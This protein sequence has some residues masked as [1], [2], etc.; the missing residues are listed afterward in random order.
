MC[1]LP[2]LTLEKAQIADPLTG[3]ITIIIAQALA[4]LVALLGNNFFQV[5]GK[6][7]F[8]GLL[9]KKLA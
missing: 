8:R 1:A 2:A 9:Y 7:F 3:A 5:P 6:L 4:I